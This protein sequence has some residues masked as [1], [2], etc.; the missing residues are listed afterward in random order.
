MVAYSWGTLDVVS[1]FFITHRVPITNSQLCGY[2][3]IMSNDD[4]TYEVIL[5]KIHSVQET[6]SKHENLA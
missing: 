6:F 4:E 3:V 2:E 1:K 5:F